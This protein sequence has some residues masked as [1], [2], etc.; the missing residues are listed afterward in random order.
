MMRSTCTHAYGEAFEF[1]KGID[2]NSCYICHN[3]PHQSRR[4]QCSEC[5]SEICI[6]CLEKTFNIKKQFNQNE[7]TD[8]TVILRLEILE[9]QY[10]L[11]DHRVKNLVDKPSSSKIHEEYLEKEIKN[12]MHIQCNTSLLSGVRVSCVITFPDQTS[13]SL[14][15]FIDTGATQVYIRHS[16]VPQSC[17][18]ILD[19]PIDSQQADG[20]INSTN[21]MVP[22]CSLTFTTNC[23]K[24]Q[25]YKLPSIYSRGFQNLHNI[26]IILGLR[27][28]L[29]DNGCLILTKDYFQI[30]KDSSYI[31]VLPHQSALEKHG[32]NPTSSNTSSNTNPY[33]NCTC[34]VPG[35][36]KKRNQNN[37]IFLNIDTK[38]LTDHPPI[39]EIDP[40]Y[41][42]Y[43]QTQEYSQQIPKIRK[44]L[45][46]FEDSYSFVSEDIQNIISR[47]EKQEI[48]GENP[49]RLGKKIRSIAH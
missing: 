5:F 10:Q 44:D 48:I 20:S 14:T 21:T 24:S 3:Y 33:P 17:I 43:I 34:P 8:K 25:T 39:H 11:L 12:D 30:L 35:A 19:K 40:D 18:K 15:G 7:K 1:E 36:C 26:D 41:D 16:L 29:K 38:E 27:F 32:G 42:F 31:P 46:H 9:K 45:S 37:Q 23:L 6:M 47:L 4:A 13:T 49:Q 2:S 22:N 28:L